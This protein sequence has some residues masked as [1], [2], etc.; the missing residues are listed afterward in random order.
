[1][2]EEDGNLDPTKDWLPMDLEAEDCI[3][4]LNPSSNQKSTFHIVIIAKQRLRIPKDVG[5]RT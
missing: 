3:G 4:A 5:G 1:M 2:Q